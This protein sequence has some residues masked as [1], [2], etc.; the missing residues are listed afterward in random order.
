MIKQN[1]KGKLKKVKDWLRKLKDKKILTKN[2]NKVRNNA[3][4]KLIKPLK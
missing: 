4:D 3:K 2:I 1:K